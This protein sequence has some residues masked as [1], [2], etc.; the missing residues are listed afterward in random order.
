MATAPQSK[1]TRPKVGPHDKFVLTGPAGFTET[2]TED[3][4]DTL[5]AVGL[6]RYDFS[7]HL[8]SDGHGN[9]L[10]PIHHFYVGAEAKGENDA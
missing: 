7:D 3:T 1:D 4:I 10:G 5:V 2:L 6:I 9:G 8:L